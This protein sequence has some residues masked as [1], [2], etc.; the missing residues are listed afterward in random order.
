MSTVKDESK[1]V[2]R[3][4]KRPKVTSSALASRKVFGDQPIKELE[5]P[6]P[7]DNY[8]HNM[9]EVDIAD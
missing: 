7:Y 6:L 8:N 5:I 4:R 9:G 1:T 3:E 2:L